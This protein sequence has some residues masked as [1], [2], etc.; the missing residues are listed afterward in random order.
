[1]ATTSV[2]MC[3]ASAMRASELTEIPTVSSTTK[4]TEMM[5]APATIGQSLRS[6]PS[7]SPDAPGPWLCV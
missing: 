7:A 3:P 6:V 5:T 2:S 4:N 1:M